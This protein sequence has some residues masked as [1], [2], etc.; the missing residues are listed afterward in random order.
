MAEYFAELG[1]ESGATSLSDSIS[2]NS[3]D[4]MNQ[5]LVSSKPSKAFRDRY[6]I[7][8]T[9][10]HV[11][12]T[13]G[14]PDTRNPVKAVNLEL[15]FSNYDYGMH[16]EVG[17]SL[18]VCASGTKSSRQVIELPILRNEI[19]NPFV[20]SVRDPSNVNLVFELCRGSVVKSKENAQIVA[21]GVALVQSLR[22]GFVSKRES[23][24]R[25][26]TVPLLEKESLR[27]VGTVTFCLLIVTPRARQKVA[28]EATRGFWRSEDGSIPVVGHRGTCDICI[29]NNNMLMTAKGLVTTLANDSAYRLERT[30][31]R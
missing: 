23:L 31:C 21:S 10:S 24:I 26:H 15:G 29:T 8:E 20:S 16:P 2:H 22:Q 18:Q 5:V 30:L 3:K 27:L 28:S 25:Y 14:S 17:Y 19:N 7:Q 1:A 4:E 6:P 13:L 12:V 9:E 11:F